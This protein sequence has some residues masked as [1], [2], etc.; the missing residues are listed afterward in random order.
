M[1]HAGG[2]NRGQGEQRFRSNNREKGCRLSNLT[3]R[4][5]VYVSAT[6]NSWPD[7]CAGTGRDG[8]GGSRTIRGE[9]RWRLLG[10]AGPDTALAARPATSSV[11]YTSHAR[12]RSARLSVRRQRP[13]TVLRLRVGM[14]QQR[15]GVPDRPMLLSA[16]GRGRLRPVRIRGTGQNPQR[17]A[18]RGCRRSAATIAPYRRSVAASAPTPK[19]SHRG[20]PNG[21]RTRLRI[22]FRS[23]RPLGCVDTYECNGRARH[24]KVFCFRIEVIAR[25]RIG[26][27]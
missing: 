8:P 27:R 2:D 18:A 20:G 24:H 12:W 17:F 14:L 21:G 5:D 10:I 7:R 3:V 25:R 11:L 6:T 23:S 26:L 13:R 15:R 1:D 16:G 22:Q 4:D 19:L 9:V